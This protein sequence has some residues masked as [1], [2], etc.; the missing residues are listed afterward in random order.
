MN[1]PKNPSRRRFIQVGTGLAAGGAA[2]AAAGLF[3][4]GFRPGSPLSGWLQP[5]RPNILLL[6]VD[7]MRYPPVYEAEGAKRFRRDYLRTQDMLRAHGAVKDQNSV[8]RGLL[9]IREGRRLR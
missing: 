7:E 6:M 4:P 8:T 3:E 1:N 9:E 5:Y 2:E